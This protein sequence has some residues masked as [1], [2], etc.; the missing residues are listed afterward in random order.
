MQIT[1]GTSALQYPLWN[2]GTHIPSRVVADMLTLLRVGMGD[3]VWSEQVYRECDVGSGGQN[4]C[5]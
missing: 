1:P 3:W 2:A 5:V 4:V